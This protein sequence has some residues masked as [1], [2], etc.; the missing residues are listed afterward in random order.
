MKT[1]S[2]S[3]EGHLALAQRSALLNSIALE[4]KQELF[5]IDT[6]IDRVIESIR[7]WYV[8]PHLIQRPVIVC[9]WGLTGTGKTQ[10]TRRLAQKLGFYDRFVEVQMDGFSNGSSW[11][12]A[13]SISAMLSESGIVEAQP[14]IL[15][16]DEF[17]RFRTVT[18]KGDDIPV[19][20]YQDVWQL[21]S[22]G[23]LPPALSFLQQL[24]TTLA[25]SNYDA[26]QSDDKSDEQQNSSAD[27][28][29]SKPK[30]IRRFK[31]SPYEAQELK[32]ALKLQDN[33]QTIMTWSPDV[34]QAKVAAFRANSEHWETDYSQLLIIV[35][36]NLDE[37]YSDLA[38]QVA[39]CDTD[40][41]L[42]HH[43]SSQLSIIDVKKALKKRFRPEQISRLGNT[44]IVYPSMNQATYLQLITSV[45]HN[46]IKQLEASSG[47]VYE[48]DNSVLDGIYANGVF[49]AQGTRPVFSS[50]HA[51][52]SAPLVNTALWAAQSGLPQNSTIRLRLDLDTASLI[53]RNALGE[54][55]HLP[56]CLDL[57]KIRRRSS[58]NFR[59][60]LAVHEAGHGLIYALLFKQAPQELKIN[61]ASF[62]GGYNSYV[63]LKAE[64]RQNRLDKICV[65]LAGRAAESWIFGAD[66]CSTGS[67]QDI[68]S[69]T[70]VAAQFVRHD[71]FGQR[72]SHT[73]I[74]TSAQEDV[75]TDLMPSNH[76]IEQLLQEQMIRCNELIENHEAL[77]L[78]IVDLLMS[79]GQVSQAQLSALLNVPKAEEDGIKVAYAQRLS[80]FQARSRAKP[81]SIASNPLKSFQPQWQLEPDPL[82][83]QWH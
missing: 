32:R 65:S 71:G 72:I 22:D 4:L 18:N 53:A 42:F 1:Y 11:R 26:D 46:Y 38:S 23:R 82:I 78:T 37:M 63:R 43:M 30:K 60:L 14:G 16:L 36:G 35:A 79:E 74:A 77:L 20:R 3:M 57:E 44:H 40:A 33:L 48:L 66:A 28:D 62:E 39:D 17:Q 52:L 2:L 24:D 41:D 58:T 5:G 47:Y 7:A 83:F 51:I 29:A 8:M 19:K 21:L 10:L 61:V 27:N 59:A 64:S 80:D 69:A 67:Y 45:C 9:L 68:K 55:K 75:N 54:Q 49:P 15:M 12:S 50:V 13:D 76:Q 6:I 56:V 70:S 25:Y 73:D 31:L 81:E 34:L